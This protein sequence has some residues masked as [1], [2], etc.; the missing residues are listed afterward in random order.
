LIFFRA[1][2]VAEKTTLDTS[3]EEMNTQLSTKP[4]IFGVKLK[5]TRN[6]RVMTAKPVEIIIKTEDKTVPT[7]TESQGKLCLKMK[8]NLT[9][10]RA[11]ERQRCH[12]SEEMSKSQTIEEEKTAV[13]KTLKKETISLKNNDSGTRANELITHLSLNTENN[14]QP[15]APNNAT[16]TNLEVKLAEVEVVDTQTNTKP[17]DT[18]PDKS[19]TQEQKLLQENANCEKPNFDLFRKDEDATST[20]VQPRTKPQSASMSLEDTAPSR[21]DDDVVDISHVQMR[22]SRSSRGRSVGVSLQMSVSTDDRENQPQDFAASSNET[23][24][25]DPDTYLH[26]TKLRSIVESVFADEEDDHDSAFLPAEICTD[27]FIEIKQYFT[28]TDTEFDLQY[29]PTPKRNSVPLLKEFLR[30]D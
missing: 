20:D 22:K 3:A 7:L 24:G 23:A 28:T 27:A 15:T 9:D 11:D 29:H 21:L 30:I 25:E 19:N 1:D 16:S 17:I 5:P 2:N 13:P 26:E 6:S 10:T 12:S 8:N 14:I 18:D 4:N